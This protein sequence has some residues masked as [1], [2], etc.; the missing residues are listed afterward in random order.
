[1]R[2]ID[3]CPGFAVRSPRTEKQG[4][5]SY[6]EQEF[7]PAR[8]RQRESCELQVIDSLVRLL[9]RAASAQSMIGIPPGPALARA[10][11]FCYGAMISTG[12][13]VIAWPP[14]NTVTSL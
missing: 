12:I 13:V 6:F 10:K 1:M 9:P 11:S 7:V 2:D 5:R 4:R 14:L 3:L 8:Q